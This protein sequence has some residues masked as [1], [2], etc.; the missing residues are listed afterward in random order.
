MSRNI[1]LIGSDSIRADHLSCY[2]Y[3]RETTPFL[4]RLAKKGVKFENAIVSGVPTLPS[5]MGMFTGK[6]SFILSSSLLP[7][8]WKK[9]LNNRKTLAQI[10]SKYRYNTYG[11]NMNALL[12]GYYGFNKGFQHYYDVLWSELTPKTGKEKLRSWWWKA[13]RLHFLP[14]LRKLGLDEYFDVVKNLVKGD[15]GHMKAENCL[16]NILNTRL[17]E[18]YF[19][20]VFLVDTHY[21]YVPPEKYAKWSK[22][23]ARKILWLNYKMIRNR[24]TNSISDKKDGW[25]MK[26]QKFRPKLNQKERKIIINSYDDEILHI[27]SI[28]RELWRYLKDTDPIIIF[29]S[30]HGDA[31]GEHGFYGHPP[32]HYEELIRV[33]LI[34]SNADTKETIKTP[35]S[36]LRVAPTICTLAGIKNE[37]AQFELFENDFIPPIVINKVQEGVRITVRHKDWKLIVNPDRKDELYNIKYDPRERE[38]KIESNISIKKELMKIV[39]SINLKKEDTE[40][41]KIKRVVKQVLKEKISKN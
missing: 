38:N 33:P 3:R 22:T 40:K 13:K 32:E 7:E 28:L 23:S 1:V 41:E 24:G 21:P 6:H 14:F 16:N 19:L 20:W 18:P 31:F 35:V 37:F 34:I 27:D 25:V 2:G 4:K 39:R 36:L 29:Y 10:F 8:I 11:F 12:S 5:T 17:K 15:T 26:Q 9:A 30:D